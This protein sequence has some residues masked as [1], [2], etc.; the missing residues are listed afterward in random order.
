MA[1]I[2][3]QREASGVEPMCAV[4]PIAPATYVWHQRWQ[5][6]PDQRSRRA[7]RDAWLMT[8]IQRDRTVLDLACGE[9]VYTRQFMRAGAAAVTGVDISPAMITLAEAAERTDPLGCRYVR[10]DAAA[11]TPSARVDIGRPSIC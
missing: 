7:Q 10:E 9:G 6:D 11:F 5:V 4:L 8:Q 3:A 1:F 2:D